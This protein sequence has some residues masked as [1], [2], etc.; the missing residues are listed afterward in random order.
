MR[1]YPRIVVGMHDLA[2]KTLLDRLVDSAKLWATANGR[3]LG[4]LASIVVNHGSFF[5]RLA[6]PGASTTTATL[7]RFARY[8]GDCSSWPDGAVPAEVRAFV[9]VT[10]ITPECD[11]PATGQA[12]EMS[13]PLA[14]G[15]AA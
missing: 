3:S 7:E 4:A 13:G 12:V 2:P 1:E 5:D 6:V 9:H 8:L 10:G 14:N 11:L 15:E